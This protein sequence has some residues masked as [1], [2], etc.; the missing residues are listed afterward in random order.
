[1]EPWLWVSSEVIEY[2]YL[3]SSHKFSRNMQCL[4]FGRS[5]AVVITHFLDVA[6]IFSSHDCLKYDHVLCA[7]AS[8]LHAC[9]LSIIL[10]PH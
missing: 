7:N 8:I 3:V 6:I 2:E 5:S 1:M 9:R 10:F 4:G